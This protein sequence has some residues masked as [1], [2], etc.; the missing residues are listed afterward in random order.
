MRTFSF[1]VLA[2]LLNLLVTCADSF[3]FAR[4][5]SRGVLAIWPESEATI[6]LRVGCPDTPLTFW[7]P[8]WTDAV[9][10]AANRW[11]VPDATFRFRIQSPTVDA[12]PCDT[13]GHRTI[14][15]RPTL[16]GPNGPGFGSSLAVT[17][18][19]LNPST[20]AF[21][22]AD[23]VFDGK[24]TWVTYDGPLRT[25]ASGAIEYDFHRVAIHE[26]GHILGL[27][28]PD[29]VGQ[30]VTAIMNRRVSNIDT[31]QPDDL[32]GVRTIYP[33][34]G[35]T[36]QGRLENPQ[37]NSAV[38]GI[39]TISGWVCAATQVT[40][41]I[42]GNIS[43]PA[44]YGTPRGDTRTTCGDDDNGFGVLVNWN[45]LGPG[46]HQMVALADG[47]EFGRATVTVASFGVPFVTGAGGAYTVQFNGR[48]VTLRWEEKLQNFVISGVQ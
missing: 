20:G 32:A 16:C 48:N 24:R 8:C 39:S 31:T 19:L 22:D 36:V 17:Y 41:L 4:E 14:A 9:I 46:T 10:D 2:G 37:P 28:H 38:S 18:F 35:T 26:L 43:I 6:N 13:D 47:V 1:V 23:T 34:A 30:T 33:A 27:D 29:D 45:D 25:N 44:A 42:N 15:F 40:V 11:H 3:A 12:D 5:V 7:G 21:V